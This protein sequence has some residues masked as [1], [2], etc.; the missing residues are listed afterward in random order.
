MRALLHSLLFIV[1][2]FSCTNTNKL[3]F[4][5]KEYHQD[6][7]SD[8]PI[9]EITI[10]NA[11]ETSAISNAI[12]TALREEIIGQLTFDDN[13]QSMEHIPEAMQSFSNGYGKLRTKFPDETVPWE[14]KIKGEVIY[15]NDHLVT[16]ACDTY[17]FTGGAHGYNSIRYLNFDKKKGIEL[18]NWELFANLED[19]KR[20]AELKFRIQ[21]AIPQD[22]NINSTGLM[23][24]NEEFYLPE[25]MGFT[26]NGLLLRYN[27][28]DVASFADGPIIITLP[29]TEIKNYLAKKIKS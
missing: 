23:F 27:Q 28:Y 12:N 6:K 29:Y 14:A 1:L 16:I 5:P 13:G 26:D 3:A 19:F 21:E 15:E 22:D 11:L 20:F 18:E 25:N 24:E 4:K 17:V 10:P 2:F 9:I 8:C 7:C